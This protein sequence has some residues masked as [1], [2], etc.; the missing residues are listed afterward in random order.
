M[1]SS[2]TVTLQQELEVFERHRF[3]LLDR[4]AGKYVLVKG[5]DIIGTFETEA[6]AIREGYQQFGNDAF[7]V[8]HVLEADVPLNFASFNLGL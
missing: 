3:E 1:M 6:E 8:K 7:L 4:A 2:T 5:L